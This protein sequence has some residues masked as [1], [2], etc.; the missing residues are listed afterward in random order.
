MLVLEKTCRWQRLSEPPR[1]KDCISLLQPSAQPRLQV[2]DTKNRP[3]RGMVYLRMFK[4]PKIQIKSSSAVYVRMLQHPKIQIN[5][6]TRKS[7][8]DDELLYLRMYKHPKIQILSIA[9]NLP[10]RGVCACS[11]AQH[12][13]IAMHS[14]A[15]DVPMI[16]VGAR[17]QNRKR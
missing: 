14:Q 4:H 11:Y 10:R 9:E 12:P 17:T 16:G 2:E 6:Q 7:A 13:K 5:P 1:T 3:S 8:H 15:E